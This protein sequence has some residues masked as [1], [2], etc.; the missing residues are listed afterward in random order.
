MNT[1]AGCRSHYRER[2]WRIFLIDFCG[3]TGEVVGFECPKCCIDTEGCQAYERP[4]AWPVGAI[5]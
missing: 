2:H 3:L 4:V 1:C 5:A